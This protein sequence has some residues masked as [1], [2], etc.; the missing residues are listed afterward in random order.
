ML[1]Y[2]HAYHAGSYADVLKHLTLL[3]I[4]SYL[5]QKESPLFYLETHAGRGRY[6][7]QDAYAQKPVKPK[8][9]LKNSGKSKQTYRLFFMIICVF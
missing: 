6:N 4:F 9:E 1:S 2:Q 7:L 3:R 8:K 5:T